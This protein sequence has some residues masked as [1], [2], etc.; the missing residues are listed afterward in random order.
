M[1]DSKP[2]PRNPVKVGAQQFAAGGAAGLIEI[3]IMQPL[4]VVKTRFQLQTTGQAGAYSSL[5]DCFKTIYRTEGL[6]AFYK[7]ILPPIFAETPKRATKFFM[8]E[9]YQDYVFVPLLGDKTKK[10]V[11]KQKT[12]LVYSLAGFCCG[13]TEAIVI[14]P[15][16]RV[17]VQ[18]QAEKGRGGTSPFQKAKEI[19]AVGGFGT[20][21]G[22]NRGLTSTIGRHS[23]WNMIYFGLYHTC[24]DMLPQRKTDSFDWNFFF[25]RIALGF[26]GGSLASIVNIPYDVA[27]S[28]I[29]G[30]TVHLPDGTEK[31]RG[32]HQ[33]MLLVAKEEGPRALFKGLAPKLMRL[34]PSGAIMMM[35]YETLLEKFA[36]WWP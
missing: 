2:V 30:P 25:K 28:R 3:L 15:F 9:I 33:T 31:Y 11:N 32:A 1:T 10:E 18:L 4:D 22:L 16:E 14:N 6:G 27:K 23:V 36:I 35:V 24:K 17:K 8:F 12:P 20:K 5:G 29:Q 13:A 26:I 34:G 21:N 7:G 19:Y